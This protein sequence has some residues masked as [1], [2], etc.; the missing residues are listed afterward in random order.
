MMLTNFH[1][2]ETKTFY[3]ARFFAKKFTRQFL[4]K[5]MLKHALTP[6]P[7]QQF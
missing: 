3:L 5:E 2:Y 1:C 6:K 4:G 7:Q